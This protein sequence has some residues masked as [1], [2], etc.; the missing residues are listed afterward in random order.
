MRKLLDLSAQRCIA[1][2]ETLMLQED[3]ISTRELAAKVSASE[4]SVA[5]DLAWL[6]KNW[7]EE[8]GMEIS[9]KNGVRVQHQSVAVMGQIFLKLFND[10]L[11]LRWIKELFF[12]PQN[13][14]EFYEAK[15]FVSRS[16]LLRLFP[17]IN[18]F[19]GDFGMAV[20]RKDN[21]LEIQSNDEQFLRQFF[22]GFLIEISGPDPSAYALPL[23]PSLLKSLLQDLFT[24]HLSKTESSFV[25]EDDI[26]VFY[27]LVFTMISL[28]RETQ[29]YGVP[30]EYPIDDALLHRSLSSLKEA[31][32]HLSTKQLQP[33]YEFMIRQ[34]IGWDSEEE[35]TN[36][37][38]AI[39]DFWSVLA[40]M[41]PSG[42]DERRKERLLFLL[43]SI[44]FTAKYRP[45]RTSV[46]FDR[47]GYFADSL[48]K[49]HRSLWDL[50]EA[51]TQT[52]AQ[53]L[54]VD[55]PSQLH[56]ILF[57]L[58]FQVPEILDHNPCRRAILVS[59][60]GMQHSTFL[61]RILEEKFHQGSAQQLTITVLPLSEVIQS[62]LPSGYDLLLT[63]IPQLIP[64]HPFGIL[65][66]DYPNPEN[67]FLLDRKMRELP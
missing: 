53:R 35:K 47:I 39:T 36:V 29:G 54:G 37:F 65:L 31:F 12:H 8:L 59:D 28:I 40:P 46:L 49:T 38:A 2:M 27:Y 19:L 48:K 20:V 9:V 24:T 50:V 57:W 60:F 26:A 58:C 61:A 14:L 51:Q 43:Q 34:Y 1:L 6:R 5:E 32:P 13:K 22:T 10:S 11:A 17:V 25:M 15:L 64:L 21:L 55:I 52:M 63:T 23:E 16:T 4:R 44:Y 7:G 30:S 33:I 62:G 3:W 18:R 42:L 66:N 45:H 41:I 67:L 56:S